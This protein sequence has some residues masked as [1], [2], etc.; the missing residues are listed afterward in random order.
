LT[1]SIQLSIKG[2]AEMTNKVSV[3]I[4]RLIW[5][6]T[7]VGWVGIFLCVCFRER[8]KKNRSKVKVRIKLEKGEKMKF[9]SG[10][11]R[12]RKSAN[13]QASKD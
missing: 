13:R 6:Q 11:I 10:E 9:R 4:V 3:P 8:K 5:R 7:R 1:N 2:G 12:P